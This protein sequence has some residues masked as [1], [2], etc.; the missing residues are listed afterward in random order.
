MGY[1]PWG[2]KELDM[3]EHLSTHRAKHSNADSLEHLN[4]YALPAMMGM[5]LK[6]C[7]TRSQT[8]THRFLTTQ[9]GTKEVVWD[10]LCSHVT[11]LDFL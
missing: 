4:G 7:C 8:K 6:L 5:R 3:T 10:T 1:S 2:L 11:I 9:K